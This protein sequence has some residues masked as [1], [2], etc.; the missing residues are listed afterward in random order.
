MYNIYPS[1][2]VYIYIYIERERYMYMYRFNGGPPTAA[3]ARV[4]LRRSTGDPNSPD[5]RFGCNS[6]VSVL[7]CTIHLYSKSSPTAIFQGRTFSGFP[8]GGIS[9]LERPC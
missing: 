6:M 2:Y 8:S 9:P 7:P 5:G 1:M 3:E 4:S